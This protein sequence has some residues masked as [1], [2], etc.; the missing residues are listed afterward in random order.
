MAAGRCNVVTVRSGGGGRV[1][2]PRASAGGRGRIE[3]PG[4]DVIRTDL[5][6][7]FNSAF[8]SAPGVDQIPIQFFGGFKGMQG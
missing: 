4:A 5:V 7:F 6:F 2:W 1:G 8:D 3:W